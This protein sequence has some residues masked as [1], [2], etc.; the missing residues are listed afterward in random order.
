MA[1]TGDGTNDAPALN[2]AHVGMS[3]GSGTSVAKQASDIT[4]IDDSFRSIVQGIMWGRSLYKN[5]QRFI[6]FQLIVN[7]AALLLVLCGAFVGTEMPLT[8]TQILWVNL[9]MD[10]FAAMALASLPPS[11]EVM[12]ERPRSQDAFIITPSMVRGIAI[13][14]G[15]FF[16]LTFA[17]LYYFER[18]AGIDDQ[19]LTIFFC[20][21]VMLQWWNLFNARCIGSCHSAFRR[22]WACQGFLLVLALVLLGQWLIVTFGGRMFRTV[23]L[24]WQTWGAIIVLT[25]LVLWVG[26]LYR[27]IQRVWKRQAA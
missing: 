21:F 9:I 11:R 1:V 2:R 5:I 7:V 14:G 3:L 25:S 15:I 17:L 8:I 22:L 18:I 20:C 23:P 19:E 12:Q 10:T 16:I 27:W 13:I 6:F 26:E 24:S 4:L